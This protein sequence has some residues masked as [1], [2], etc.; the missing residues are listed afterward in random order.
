MTPNKTQVTKAQAEKC[1][2]AVKDRYKAWLGDGADEP[3]L[4]MKFDWFGD[5]G[6]AI[7]WEGGPYE[8]TMLVYG[9]IEEEFGFKLEAVEFPKT[10]F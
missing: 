3:V 7:V 6:P 9:G 10:V 2:A 1:L 8:W 4:R 5:P